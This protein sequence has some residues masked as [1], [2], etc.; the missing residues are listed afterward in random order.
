[1]SQRDRL[2]AGGDA[3]RLYQSAG[4]LAALGR[5]ED[6]KADYLAALAQAPTHFGALND[7]V[8]YTHLTLPTKRI[9]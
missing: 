3:E 6:A 1:M 7:P 2:S 8:S 5:F 9:V 4:R